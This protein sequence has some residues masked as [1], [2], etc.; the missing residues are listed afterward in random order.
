MQTNLELKLQE[1]YGGYENLLS[2]S[3]T[4]GY[5]TMQNTDVIANDLNGRTWEEF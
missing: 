3:R 5:K 4:F 2:S 1:L